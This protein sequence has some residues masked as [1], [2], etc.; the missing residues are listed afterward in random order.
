LLPA[1]WHGLP[2]TRLI[3]LKHLQVIGIV[4]Y[5]EAVS[6]AVGVSSQPLSEGLSIGCVGGDIHR[7]SVLVP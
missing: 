6:I 5:R 4:V 3:A 2:L 1:E 7:L